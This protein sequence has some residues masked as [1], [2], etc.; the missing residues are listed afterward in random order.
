MKGLG[1]VIGTAVGMVMS[2]VWF[3]VGAA[4]ALGIVAKSLEQ[5][6]KNAEV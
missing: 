4:C 2:T 5:K 3:V 1:F 6:G